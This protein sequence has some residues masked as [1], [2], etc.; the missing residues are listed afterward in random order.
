MTN[1][2]GTLIEFSGVDGSGKS[3][4]A[5]L[6]YKSL[7]KQGY[8]CIIHDIYDRFFYSLANN[9]YSDSDLRKIY[10]VDTAETLMICD[11]IIQYE[12]RIKKFINKGYIVLSARSLSDRYLKAILYKSNNIDDI[13]KLC[14]LTI[15][16]DIHFYMKTKLETIIKRIINRGSDYEDPEMMKQY[17]KIANKEAAKQKWEIINSENEINKVHLELLYIVN[18]YLLKGK[19]K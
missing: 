18:K 15:K 5:K 12:N 17:I 4:Q 16:P 7:S 3:T 13:K 2:N 10:S 9:I 11:E 6:L 19:E 8:K 14:L 1:K